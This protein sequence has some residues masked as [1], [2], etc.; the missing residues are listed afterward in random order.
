MSK[1]QEHVQKRL[2]EVSEEMVEIFEKARKAKVQYEELA[3]LYKNITSEEGY[4]EKE[5]QE[6]FERAQMRYNEN[7]E[8]IIRFNE[9]QAV[10]LELQ[11]LLEEDN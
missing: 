1:V 6:I 4:D 5:V 9:K 7:Q 2:E 8:A 3:D 11:S 10:I